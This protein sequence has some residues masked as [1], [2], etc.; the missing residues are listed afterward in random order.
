MP[1]FEIICADCS[2]TGEILVTGHTA[3]MICPSCGS[4][5]TA[6][7]MSATSSLTGRNAQSLPGPRDTGCCGSHPG[8]AEGCAGPGSCCGR[9]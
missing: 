7:L 3:P 8:Q 4:Q 9:R 2:H 5:N 6:K 1:I